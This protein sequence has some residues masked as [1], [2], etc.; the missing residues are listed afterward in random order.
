M[1]CFCVARLRPSAPV[2][3]DTPMMKTLLSP[4]RARLPNHRPFFYDRAPKKLFTATS[5]SQTNM[6]KSLLALATLG[7][8]TASAHAQSSVTLYGLIDTGLVYTNN[9]QG[10][11]NWQM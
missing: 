10:H 3:F 4:A 11:S 1:R 6:K 7:V 2:I 9:Q 8:F 5:R